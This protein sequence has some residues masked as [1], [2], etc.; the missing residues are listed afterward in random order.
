MNRS[1]YTNMLFINATLPLVLILF[2]ANAL[3]L[4]KRFQ[5]AHVSEGVSNLTL[6]KFPGSS[7]IG[8]ARLCSRYPGC[9]SFSLAPGLCTLLSAWHNV[10]RE[11]GG[12][13]YIMKEV[14]PTCVQVTG[15]NGGDPFNLSSAYYAS[16]HQ[17]TSIRFS[18]SNRNMHGY[19]PLGME[20]HHGN[21]VGRTGYLNGDIEECQLSEGE[22]IQRWEYSTYMYRGITPVVRCNTL[23]TTHKTCGPFGTSCGTME[24][25][26]GYHL[27]YIAGRESNAFDRL[28]L[29][30]ASCW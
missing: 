30:F 5:K 23:V 19:R 4:T 25:L 28:S 16:Y 12:V 11:K 14:E 2:C 6:A 26:E 15:T 21:D 7:D 22:F 24:A 8:C 10:K 18:Y 3:G 29:A 1:T 13:T 9:I 20:V 27:L 17:I